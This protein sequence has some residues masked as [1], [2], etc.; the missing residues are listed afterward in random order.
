MDALPRLSRRAAG[1]I[2]AALLAFGGV[3]ALGGMFLFFKHVLSV[4]GDTRFMMTALAA[5]LTASLLLSLSRGAIGHKA[6]SAMLLGLVLIEIANVSTYFFAPVTDDKRLADLRKMSEDADI[7]LYLSA[8]SG[9]P[10]ISVDMEAIPYNVGHWWGMEF[11]DAYLA[12]APALLWDSEPFSVRDA[13]AA[14]DPLFC[15]HEAV[16]GPTRRWCF[17]ARAAAKCSSFPRRCRACG[18][19]TRTCV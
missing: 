15:G 10:R 9:K 4:T 13:V 7:R 6:A 3:L 19:S 12:S 5:V 16:D 17:R 11:F 8:Q 1:W 14:G 2:A 18:A